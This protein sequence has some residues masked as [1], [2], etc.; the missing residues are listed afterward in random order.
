M[1]FSGMWGENYE[2]SIK[3]RVKIG[4]NRPGICPKMI[5]NGGCRLKLLLGQVSM[6]FAPFPH[7]DIF[8]VP[9]VSF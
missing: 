8:I 9:C 5:E 3:I 7:P 2:C 6:V 4:Q 1:I